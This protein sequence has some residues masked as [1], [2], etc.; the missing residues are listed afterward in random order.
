MRAQMM[1]LKRIGILMILTV[2]GLGT[3]LHAAPSVV[4]GAA[5]GAKFNLE[6]NTH[7]V[8]QQLEAVE[9]PQVEA[10]DCLDHTPNRRLV[11]ESALGCRG[12]RR[13]RGHAG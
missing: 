11:I 12:A 5:F 13:L 3:E 9:R 10:Q 8:P 2:L 4:C 1:T 6:P 7:A